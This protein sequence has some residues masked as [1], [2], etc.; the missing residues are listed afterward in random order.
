[1]A[2]NFKL[3]PLGVMNLSSRRIRSVAVGAILA[4][5]VV[6]PVANAFASPLEFVPWRAD[7]HMHLR[8]QSAYDATAAL[9]SVFGK[10]AC[11]LPDAEHAVL[12]ATDALA[13]LDDAHVRN[14]VVLSMAYIFGSPYLS[15]QH[16][17]VTRLTRSE[18]EYV[19]DQVEHSEGR[20]IGFCSVDPLS[21]SAP[22][23][24]RYWSADR[25]LRGLKLHLTSS[26]VNLKDPAQVKQVANIVALAGDHRLP[27]VIHLRSSLDFGAQ[28]TE[29]FIRDIL[30][31][32]RDSIVQIAHASGWS[33]TDRVMF[34]DLQTFAVHIARNDP[35]TRHVLFDLSG[36]VSAATTTE[37]AT[38]LAALMRRIGLSRFLMGSDYDFSTPRATDDLARAKLPLANKEWQKIARNCAP[39]T[40]S[41]SGSIHARP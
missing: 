30:P 16:Y 6:L 39:W 25:R 26:A 7:H 11:S 17:D 37:E 19:A 18:N 36:V 41:R 33:G 9:C 31:R 5:L 13:A 28:D 35:A 23:E 4:C 1:M 14:G 24:V 12:G 2:R 21:P 29:I 27:M 10:Q 34:D 8:S 22:E 32:A 15:S 38:A 40:C 20:L 3:L